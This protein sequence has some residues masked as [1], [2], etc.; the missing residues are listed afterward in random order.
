MKIIITICYA[1]HYTSFLHIYL[2]GLLKLVVPSNTLNADASIGRKINDFLIS[3]RIFLNLNR[4]LC[5]IYHIP[6]IIKRRHFFCKF[7]R[8]WAHCKFRICCI[9]LVF[10]YLSYLRYTEFIYYYV[11]ISQSYNKWLEFQLLHPNMP[12]LRSTDFLSIV[13]DI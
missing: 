2:S 11:K 6:Q 1:S 9:V 4:Y 3:K 10:K 5:A 8:L 12:F 13:I 7:C